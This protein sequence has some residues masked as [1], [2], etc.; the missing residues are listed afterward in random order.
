EEALEIARQVAE[1]LEVAHEKG[2]VHRDLKPANIKL[3][4]QGGVK[5]LDFGLAAS[6]QPLPMDGNDPIHPATLS[7]ECVIL[8]TAPYM[9][10]EQARGNAVDKRS[11][12]WAFGAVLYEMLTGRRAFN[13]ETIPDTLTAILTKEPE[14][15]RVPSKVQPLLRRCL[16]KDPKRRLR[17]IADFVF[18]LEEQPQAVAARPGKTAWAVSGLATI[19]ALTLG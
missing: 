13:G 4:P 11:D 5:I 8:G 19:A 3:T 15:D 2:I 17:D 14:W 7:L 9:S 18:L 1:G 12:I 10:P 6:V 16:Q